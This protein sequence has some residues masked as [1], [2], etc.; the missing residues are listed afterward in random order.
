[1]AQCI[2]SSVFLAHDALHLKHA[3]DHKNQ[4]KRLDMI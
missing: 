1:M 3:S 2:V 4:D